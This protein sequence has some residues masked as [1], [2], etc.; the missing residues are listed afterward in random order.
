MVY[1]P[2]AI[3]AGAPVRRAQLERSPR[4]PTAWGPDDAVNWPIRMPSK[5]R[6]HQRRRNLGHRRRVPPPT[7]MRLN[8]IRRVAFTTVVGEKNAIYARRRKYRRH[9][10]WQILSERTRANLADCPKVNAVVRVNATFVR[11]SKRPASDVCVGKVDASGSGSTNRD[12]CGNGA[13]AA[14]SRGANERASAA[15]AWNNEL[16]WRCRAAEVALCSFTRRRSR[17]DSDARLAHRLQPAPH[18][19]LQTPLRSRRIATGVPGG[20]PSERDRI[21]HHARERFGDRFS[22]EEPVPGQQLI[23]H[24]S[25]RPDIGPPVRRLPR[26][27]LRTHVRR[28]A[29]NQPGFC[30]AIG[31]VGDRVTRVWRWIRSRLQASSPARNRAPSRRLP[32][33]S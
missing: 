14:K 4:R 10:S 1:G 26:R 13:G 22:A 25:K 16:A 7:G 20:S 21:L 27:L 17:L 2:A 8:V 23:Q 11:P 24:Y 31:S 28:G 15:S 5:P 30:G 12:G 19:A 32:A 18:V 9:G 29:Q 3:R 33:S 6:S